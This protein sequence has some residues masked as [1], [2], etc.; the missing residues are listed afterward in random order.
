VGIALLLTTLTVVGAVVIDPTAPP[1]IDWFDALRILASGFFGY[2]A[3]RSAGGH[4][5]A[6]VDRHQ[7]A[8]AQVKAAEEREALNAMSTRSMTINV[9]GAVFSK[10]IKTARKASDAT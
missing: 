2:M 3:A 4:F 6:R 8:V 7:A 1:T 5:G 9:D 10:A